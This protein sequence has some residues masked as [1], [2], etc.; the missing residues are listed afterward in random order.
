VSSALDLR[1]PPRRSDSKL[2]RDRLVLAVGEWV[3]ERGDAPERLADLATWSGISVATAYRHFASID[4]VILAYVLRLPENAVTRFA[5]ADRA[6]LTA[7][8]RL[9][10]WNRAWV[11]ACLEFGPV[12][13]H[14]RSATGFLRRRADGEPTVAYV[15]Q[16]V[17]PLL[18][19][20]DDDT[21]VMLL[22][23]NAVSDPREVLDL[24]DTLGWGDERI[25]RFIT[26]TTL[27]AHA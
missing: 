1:T 10:R 27:R 26:D 12:A 24:R 9:H 2:T 22:V 3:A 18:A 20:I 21:V 23:W 25:A 8:D 7:A 19:S 11:R 15:C 14:L 17:E 6:G 16:Q 5:R 13:V 4:D